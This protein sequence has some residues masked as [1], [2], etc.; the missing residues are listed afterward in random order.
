MIRGRRFALLLALP[1]ALSG[2]G[3][4]AWPEPP[5]VDAAVYAG[6]HAEWRAG[7]RA[8]A[9][10]TLAIVGVWPL[11]EGESPFGADPALPIVLPGDGVPSRAGSFRRAGSQVI[12]V[13]APAAALAFPDG[14]A[15]EQASE[16]P[17]GLRLGSLRLEVADAGDERRWVIASR[18][19][20]ASAPASIES[21][22]LDPQWRLQAR[23]DAFTMPRP[24]QVPDVRGGEMTF[25]A[26]GQIVFRRE[27]REHRLTAFGEPGGGELFVMFRDATTAAASGGGYR[28][29]TPAVVDDGE[30]TVVD[31]NFAGN[32]PCAYS[33]F[34]LCPLPP[35][36]NTLPFAVEAGLERPPAARQS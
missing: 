22:P 10:D 4:R 9:A 14:T 34:T 17:E 16:V 26:L 24:V 12:V 28:I 5:A 33:P 25:L 27:G 29:L 1:L 35:P 32:P 13:P 30:Y 36:E 18:D 20:G 31:F 11:A 8:M 6:Q 23:F 3:A 7:Q 19:G 21:Y 2:C 15:L